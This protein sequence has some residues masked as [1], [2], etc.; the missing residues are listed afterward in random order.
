MTGEAS[1]GGAQ[2]AVR[3]TLVS[4]QGERALGGVSRGELSPLI[5]NFVP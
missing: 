2:R 4:L 5:L 1:G 3:L